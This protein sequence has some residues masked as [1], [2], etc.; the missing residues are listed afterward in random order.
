M[1]D[2]TFIVTLTN[3]TK[4]AHY[5][6]KLY[7]QARKRVDLKKAI[8]SIRLPPSQYADSTIWTTEQEKHSD[9]LCLRPPERKGVPIPTLH[10]A[11]LRFQQEAGMPFQESL[12]TNN[13]A[14]AA[15]AL[16]CLMGNSYK[17]D[18]DRTRDF[19]ECF[20]PIYNSYSWYILPYVYN[21][22]EECGGRIGSASF[23]DHPPSVVNILRQDKVEPGFDGDAYMQVARGYHMYVKDIGRTSSPERKAALDRGAPMFLLCVQ[24]EL[25]LFIPFLSD[26][27]I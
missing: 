8:A 15:D 16:S 10:E 19:N 27:Y 23:P 1:L 17:D 4:Q 12:E 22:S 2:P 11:F 13:A 20:S 7:S 5:A 21:T 9:I 25:G 24:G 6:D 26:L 18:T 14:R 3:W